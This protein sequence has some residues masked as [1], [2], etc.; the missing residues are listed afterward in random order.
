MKKKN[1]FYFNIILIEIFHQMNTLP[2]Y[3][4][5]IRYN[6]V[7]IRKALDKRTNTNGLSSEG[8]KKI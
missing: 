2:I 1:K 6:L 5:Y 7:P 3:D 4:E 8:K